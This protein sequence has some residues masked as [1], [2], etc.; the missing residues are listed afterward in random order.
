MITDADNS[1]LNRV[2]TLFATILPMGTRITVEQLDDID[3]TVNVAGTPLR[4][5]F[6][7]RGDFR[8]VQM[9]LKARPRPD[10]IAA[11]RLSVASRQ[12]IA[13]E[14]INWADERGAASIEA[15]SMVIALSGQIPSVR[16]SSTDWTPAAIGVAEAIL[17]GTT[18]TAEAVAAAT[19]HSLSTA[20]RVLAFLVGRGLLEAPKARGPQSG[21]RIVDFDRL[22]DQYSEAA[23]LRRPKFELR[24]GLLWREL[25]TEIKQIGK[26]WTSMRVP[27]SMAGA[28]AASIQAPY[29][30]QT[31][32]GVVYVGASREVEMLQIARQAGLEVMEGGRLL[33]LPFPTQ[34][35]KQ[36]IQEKD[37]VWVTSWPRTYAD[38]RNE[39]VRGEEAAEH[40]R[41]VFRGN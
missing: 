33:L 35:T 22:L 25:L 20:V 19:G 17:S 39:G 15:G 23:H 26:K 1:L 6:A 2:R 21:R 36:L 13:K 38:L 18:P 4:V 3:V 30:T 14:G 40:L 28:L 11:S 5:R 41:E 16:R 37:G 32:T 29:L 8:G 10:V 34:A 9:A 7:G 27:W 12:A 31:P 24:C